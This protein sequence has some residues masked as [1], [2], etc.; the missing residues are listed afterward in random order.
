MLGVLQE[1]TGQAGVPG[2]STGHRGG[3][4]VDDQVPGNAAEEGPG[5]FQAGDHFIQVLAV[6]GPQEAVPGVG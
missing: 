4:I 3:K 5:C 6:G 2:V 1:A